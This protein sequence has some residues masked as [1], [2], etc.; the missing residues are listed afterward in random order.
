MSK[1]KIKLEKEISQVI[2]KKDKSLKKIQNDYMTKKITRDVY[3]KR[4]DSTVNEADAKVEILTTNL[5]ELKQREWDQKNQKNKTLKKLNGNQADSLKAINRANSSPVKRPVKEKML[6]EENIMEIRNVHKTYVTGKIATPVLKGI[7]FEIKQGEFVMLFGKSGSG[8]S[9]L[10]NVMSGLDR[11]TK[12]EIVS[13]EQNVSAMKEAQ[14]TKFRRRHVGF[15]FQKY[16]L[17]PNLNAYENA[18]TGSY[19]QKDRSKRVPIADIFESM[20]IKDVM[21]KYPSEMSGGQQQRVSIARALAKN[22]EILFADEP[23]GALDE[24]MTLVVLE[25]LARIN[26]EYNTTIIM[27]THNPILADMA[28]K[29]V[30]L[31]NG[32]VESIK[33]NKKPKK[34]SQLKW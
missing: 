2:K 5:G 15:I 8:K 33:V 28:T 25:I 16:N 3:N 32:H 23:T 20:D 29:I 11:V 30:T 27:V 12:G 13:L 22:P 14:I 24:K 10:L 17:L 1:E 26:K 19:L 4:F 9:T 6:S 18:E 7:N 34:P 31:R 21:Y